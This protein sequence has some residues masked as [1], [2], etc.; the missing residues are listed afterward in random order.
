M[1][2]LRFSDVGLSRGCTSSAAGQSYGCR[3]P[4]VSNRAIIISGNMTMAASVA[5][6]TTRQRALISPSSNGKRQWKTIEHRFYCR[7][8]VQVETITKFCWPQLELSSLSSTLLHRKI[9][10]MVHWKARG[11]KD[12][13]TGHVV[14][15]G[16]QQ[17]SE[18]SPMSCFCPHGAGSQVQGRGRFA[19][20]RYSCTVHHT[21][22]RKI[23]TS[24]LPE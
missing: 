6:T 1:L 9:S 23:T 15:E 17:I 19:R 18:K 13:F 3:T 22:G 2:S 10:R 7:S 12:N 20:E 4:H 8:F 21:H 14:A 11:L 16:V 5:N 24:L